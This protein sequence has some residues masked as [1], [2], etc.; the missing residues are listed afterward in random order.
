MNE[1]RAS[2]LAPL[3]SSECTKRD[4]IDVILANSRGVMP[5]PGPGLQDGRGRRHFC[6]PFPRRRGRLACFF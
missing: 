4:G 1:V 5:R 2:P 3:V 6:A